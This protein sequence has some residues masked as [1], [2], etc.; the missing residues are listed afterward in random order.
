MEPVP[1]PDAATELTE[2]GPAGAP[3]DTDDD[4]RLAALYAYPEGLTRC[5]VRA[6]MIQSLDGG[7]TDAGKS[8]GLADSGDRAIFSRMRQEA[9]V[10]V[11]GASTVRV[12]N[13]SGVRMPA[14]QRQVRQARG[15]AEVP[16]IAVVTHRADFDHDAKLFTSTEVPPLILTARATVPD[17][18]ARFGALA[19]VVDASRGDAEQVDPAAVLDELNGRG[20][21]R[22]L[23][24]GGPS[25]I[26][27]FVERDLLDE[28]CVTL[29]PTLVGG[30]AP[31]IVTGPGQT[32]VTLRRSHVLAD[33][34]GYLYMRYAREY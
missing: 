25:L 18:R 2:L 13:Y 8:G 30:A 26:G 32:R 33:D 20:L 24:E 4:A 3:F 15:Q 22:V 28:L 21:R 1:D 11:V 6:N 29:S 34:A 31:R 10:I 7:A 12:E 16:P 23:T 14:G 27:L 17:A 19:E 9:D 5:W